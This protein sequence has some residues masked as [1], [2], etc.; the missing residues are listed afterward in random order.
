MKNSKDYSKKI[1]K[2]YRSLSRKYPKVHKISHEKVIDAIIHAIISV[3]M[4]E[5][6]TDSIIR[7]L[8]AYFVDWNDLRVSRAEEIVEVLGKDTPA[9][10]DIALTITRI[11]NGIF[12]EYHKISLES[13]KKIGK[14]PAKQALEKIDGIS[15]FVVE[16][17]LLTSLGGH[18]IPLTDKMI[19]YLRN[20]ELVNPAAD[21]QQI[22]GFLAKQIS[23][24]NGYEF[25][26][27]LRHESESAKPKKKI[28]A[29]TTPKKKSKPKTKSKAKPTAHCQ[30]SQ[31][32]GQP[33]GSPVQQ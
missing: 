18:A 25:Y 11:F 4:S 33:R 32:S 8:T 14:R 27:L 22:G 20:N 19:K 15:R 1:Q 21:D 31:Y 7:K 3:E 13:L 30:Q 9:T 29:K 26:A 23:A 16:Y 6:T 5:K 2:L 17:C 24:K 28:K 12:N 10:M